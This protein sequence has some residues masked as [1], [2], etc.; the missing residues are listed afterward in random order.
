MERL[1]QQ[2]QRLRIWSQGGLRAPHKPLLLLL[3]LA[4]AQ[5]GG[6]RLL[7]FA[8]IE[9]QLKALLEDF[10]PARGVQSPEHPFWRLQSD[11]DFWEI[12]KRDALQDA[13]R[14][15]KKQG[16][17]P[18]KILRAQGAEAGFTQEVH[19]ALRRDPALVNALV[20]ELLCRHFP[21][22]LHELLLDAVEMPWVP[23]APPDQA[24]DAAR[25]QLQLRRVRNPDFRRE[26]LHVYGCRCAVCGYDGRLGG[27]SVGVEAAH[28]RWF[29]HEGPDEVENGL[30]LCA[31]HHRLLDFGAFGL[32]PERRIVV[33]GR[34]AQSPDALSALAPYQDRPLRDPLQAR[35]VAARHIQW[36]KEQVFKG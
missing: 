3:A 24:A 28:V 5:R 13:I 30:A 33:S 1:R 35:P 22:S 14:G 20:S 6:P 4:N 26:I 19:D 7:L 32:T 27:Q 12:P 2:L 15:L 36:H 9:P 16:Y 21:E 8:D 18:P 17:I 29:A 31:L 11:G 10:G 25:F 23:P 34:F